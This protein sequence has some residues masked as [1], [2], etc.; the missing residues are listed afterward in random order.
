VIVLLLSGTDPK[1]SI[2]LLRRAFNLKDA[3]ACVCKDQPVYKLRALRKADDVI[4]TSCC[5][6]GIPQPNL[7]LA[8]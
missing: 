6:R 3:C 4:Q 8:V 2:L 1:A 7:Y 5:H